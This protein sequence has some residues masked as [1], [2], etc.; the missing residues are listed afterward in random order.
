MSLPCARDAPYRNEVQ[1]VARFFAARHYGHFVVLNLC[2]GFEEGGNG[3]YDQAL[4]YNQV[5]RARI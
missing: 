4:L 2:E 5:R 1:Q 3:N